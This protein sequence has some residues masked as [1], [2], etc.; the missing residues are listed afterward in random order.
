VPA[1]LVRGVLLPFA[2]LFRTAV[3][4]RNAAYDVGVL[5]GPRL[6]RFA[7]GVG[8]LSVGGTGKTPLS[9]WLAAELKRRGVTAGIVLRGYGND[10]VAEHRAANPEAAVEADA[11]RHA[12][13][14]RAAARGAEV[15]VLDDCLQRRDVPVDV[16]LAVVSAD[17]WATTRWPLPMGP[18]REDLGALGRADAVIV[19][20]KAANR[21]AADALALDL[22]P[23]CRGG[24]V[25]TAA[26]V[27]AVFRPL[28]GGPDVDPAMLA[29]RDVVALSGIGEPELF[30]EQLRRLGARVTPLAFPDHHRY[31][32]G[33]V[34]AARAAANGRWIITTA[35]DA[36]KLRGL[37]TA[38]GPACYV[39][40]LGVDIESGAEALGRLLDRAATAA[41]SI[42]PEVAAAL[43]VR[44]S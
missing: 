37:W 32:A 3:W 7:I 15:L 6:P 11:D 35:K 17:T 25:C 5:K 23:W 34:A 33:E 14:V 43:P 19:T 38:E 41:R 29:G 4:L 18:W 27:P 24:V 2:A 21:E 8:N 16:M 39:A 26:L 40:V 1:R 36:V 10:E 9:G 42:N 30:A 13:A 22:A 12:A 44:E 20:R 28:S 31:T